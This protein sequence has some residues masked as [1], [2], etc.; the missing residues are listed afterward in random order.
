MPKTETPRPL[1]KALETPINLIK[2]APDNPRKIPEKAVEQVA[3][4]I[5][6]F[7]WQ[8]PLVTD[9]DRVIIA[10]H[11]RYLAAKK[12]GLK[13]VP[14][15]KATHLTPKQA[16]AYR[17]ADNR[18]H[19]YTTW[20]YPELIQQINELDDFNDVLDVQ[21]WATVLESIPDPEPLNLDEETAPAS[22]Q[23]A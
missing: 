7:G 9:K 13:T 18:S 23:P 14:C 17:I 2:P 21:D 5:Q 4:S 8:Q 16:H 6:E 12:L 19:D 1:G 10:G 11:T 15:I 22:S 20:D 3:K